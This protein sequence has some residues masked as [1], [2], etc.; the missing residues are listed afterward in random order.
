V[1]GDPP[2]PCRTSDVAPRPADGGAFQLH[3]AEAVR[4]HSGLDYF[5]LLRLGRRRGKHDRS[6]G[7]FVVAAQQR[8][9]AQAVDVHDRQEIVVVAELEFLSVR[10]GS[11]RMEVR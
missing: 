5:E 7:E 1:R 9:P 11:L 8:R 3:N 10:V 4:R 6:V 2:V